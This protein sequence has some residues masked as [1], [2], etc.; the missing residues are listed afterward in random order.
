MITASAKMTGTVTCRISAVQGG[1]G[2]GGTM[3]A[4]FS[5]GSLPSMTLGSLDSVDLGPDKGG[6]ST[7]GPP[8]PPPPSSATNT[9]IANQYI[10]ERPMLDNPLLQ[11]PNPIVC[12]INSL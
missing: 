11:P 10:R 5:M 7:S 1:T 12:K 3:G 8:P 9:A 6:P 4:Q 2:G